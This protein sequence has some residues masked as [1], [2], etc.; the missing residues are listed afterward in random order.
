M[1]FCKKN[2][3][4]PQVVVPKLE[5]PDAERIRRS[6]KLFQDR[7]SSV[8]DL[9]ST[10]EKP[11]FGYGAAQMVPTLAYHLKSDLDFL[12]CI[13]DDNPDKNGLYYPHLAPPIR[14]KTDKNHWADVSIVLTALDSARPLLSRLMSQPVKHIINPLQCF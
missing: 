7:L 10:L 8:S 6:Y 3:D 13:W 2:A 12:E 14:L 5:K 1:A 9:I 11:I 4:Y